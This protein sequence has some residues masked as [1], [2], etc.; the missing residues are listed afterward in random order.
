MEPTT[1]GR[2]ILLATER[3]A[4]TRRGTGTGLLLA[5]AFSSTSSRNKPTPNGG[6]G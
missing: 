1:G 3:K 4:A 6:S 5:N 2:R